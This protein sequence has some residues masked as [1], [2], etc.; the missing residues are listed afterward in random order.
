MSTRKYWGAVASATAI[1]AATLSGAAPT[2]QAAPHCPDM[3]VV[4]IPGTWETSRAAPREG[5]V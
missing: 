4:A 2:A 5:R 3:Y 1:T